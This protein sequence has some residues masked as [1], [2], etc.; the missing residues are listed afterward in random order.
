MSSATNN[1]VIKTIED[2][3]YG[4]ANLSLSYAQG[5]NSEI[6]HRDEWVSPEILFIGEMVAGDVLLIII[7]NKTFSQAFVTSHDN[8]IRT[9]IST[10][11]NDSFTMGL[12]IGISEMSAIEISGLST[13]VIFKVEVSGI[14][15]RTYI[16]HTAAGTAQTNIIPIIWMHENGVIPNQSYVSLHII[17]TPEKMM[18]YAGKVEIPLIQDPAYPSDPT[19]KIADPAWPNGKQEIQWTEE[20]VT[21]IKGYGDYSDNYLEAL[22]MF[23][24]LSI[25]QNYLDVNYL[26]AYLATP[27]N[28]MSIILDD[29]ADRRCGMDVNFRSNLIMVD[30]PGWIDNVIY[31]GVVGSHTI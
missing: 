16:Q 13:R 6:R 11:N 12:G 15:I 14:N 20:Y 9:I 22:R 28:D 29:Q 2:R 4:W 10:I 27:I 21:S 7:N 3:I 19:K 24:D 31:A 23:L 26:S 17:T 30:E 5:W 25:V 1:S 8:T 18:K